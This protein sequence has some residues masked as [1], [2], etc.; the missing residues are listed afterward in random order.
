[1]TDDSEVKCR[2]VSHCAHVFPQERIEQLRAIYKQ[3]EFDDILREMY[4]DEFWYEKP[5]RKGNVLFM[6]KNPYDPEGYRKGCHARRATQGILS[7][8]VRPPLSG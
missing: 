4:R 8:P 7:L 3:G 5:R 6:R 1:M 2:V